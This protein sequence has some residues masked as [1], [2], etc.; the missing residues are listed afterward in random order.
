MLAELPLVPPTT[1]RVRLPRPLGDRE[2]VDIG[3]Y[4][5]VTR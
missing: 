4:P 3:V 2:L 5:P 1:V